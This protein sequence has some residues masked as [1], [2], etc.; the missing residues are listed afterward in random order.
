MY[1]PPQLTDFLLVVVIFVLVPFV[2]TRRWFLR[3]VTGERM[4]RVWTWASGRMNAEDVPEEILFY[5]AQARADRMRAD[6]SRIKHLIATDTYMS[7]VRQLGNRMAYE[8]LLDQLRREPELLPP[9]DTSDWSRIVRSPVSVRI[10]QAD[11][12]SVETLDI[13]W[14]S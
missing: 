3:I 5:R 2:F 8:Q 10:A 1:E 6:L 14:R 13:G 7:A 4:E 11:N 12:R 9:S